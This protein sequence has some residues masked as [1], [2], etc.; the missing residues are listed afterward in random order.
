ME[1][2]VRNSDIAVLQRC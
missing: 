2:H 1:S